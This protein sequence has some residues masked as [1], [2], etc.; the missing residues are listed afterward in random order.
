VSC[1]ALSTC[2][3]F[4]LAMKKSNEKLLFNVSRKMSCGARGRFRE[5]LTQL[6]Y[7]KCDWT[8]Q[9]LALKLQLRVSR[10]SAH[11]HKES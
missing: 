1:C 5:A 9:I 8:R 3:C 4:A 7:R 10:V 6:Q 11:L 2:W